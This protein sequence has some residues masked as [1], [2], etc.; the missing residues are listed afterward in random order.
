MVAIGRR[1]I[2]L[3]AVVASLGGGAATASAHIQ[4]APTLAAPEDAVRFDVLVPG[5]RSPQWT[6]R[7]VLK[8]PAGVLPYSYEATPGWSRRLVEAADGSVDR[9]VWSGRMAADGFVEFSFL[10]ATPPRPGVLEW[11]ALQVY[12]DGEVVRWIGSPS[13]EE[14]APRTAIE[15]DAPLR[16]AGG[17]GASGSDAETAAQEAAVAAAD[18]AEAEDGTDWVARGLALAAVL[19][20]FAGLALV[21]SGR[22]RSR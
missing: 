14:P 11:K 9:I 22:K 7:V 13:S 19:V 10:A 8:V 4:V 21:F 6:K 2:A 1:S 16:N 5:E 3:L 20:A 18:G 15:A 12:S 17:E